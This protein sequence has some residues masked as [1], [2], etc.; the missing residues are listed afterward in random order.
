MGGWFN[1]TKFNFMIILNKTLQDGQVKPIIHKGDNPERVG[2]IM[3]EEELHGFGV[4]VLVGFFYNQ[5]GKLFRCNHNI[6]N[7]YPHIVVESPKDGLLYV[8]VKTAMYPIIPSIESIE[9]Q[10][11]VIN[12]ANQFNAIPVFAGL[13]LT[14]VSTEENNIPICGGE[15]IAEF[16]GLKLF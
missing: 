1:D 2:E 13:R 11:E 16:T 10:D 14:C 3:T 12:L 8:W 9:N 4:G 5:K 15:Y 6:S 7:D